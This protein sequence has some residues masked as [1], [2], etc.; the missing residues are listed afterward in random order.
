MMKKKFLALIVAAALGFGLLSGCGGSSSSGGNTASGGEETAGQTEE[1]EKAEDTEN[2]ETAENTGDAAAADA[3]SGT[4]LTEF[5]VVLDWYPN[6]VHTFLYEAQNKGYF[7]EEGLNVNIISPAESVDALTFVAAGRAQIGF[8]YPVDTVNAAAGQGMPVCAIGAV[9]QEELSCMASL[10]E[11]D[12]TADMASLK[13]K[14]VGHSGPAVEEAIIRTIIKNAGL[15]EEDVELLNVGFDL[16]TSLTT[17]STDM[18]VG[19]F[20]NDEIVTMKNAGYDVNVWHYQD[21][22][23]PQMYGLVL[24]ANRDAYDA[25]PALYQGFLRACKKGFADMQA[26]EEAALATI[27]ADMNSDDN[28]LDEAQQRE[29]YEILLPLMEQEGRP[30]LSMQESDWQAAIDWMVESGLLEETCEASEVYIAE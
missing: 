24:L 3:A 7:A 26:D 9:V 13:G 28:P 15:T 16:T 12:I 6:A 22:G 11:T 2:T 19:T 23:V 14:T 20:I 4:E 30:F 5:D 8:S 17:K 1:P 18:V 21:Y 27:M 29:S 25:D 10:A